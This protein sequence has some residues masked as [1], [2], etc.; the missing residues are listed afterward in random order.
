[1]KE[2]CNEG[3]ELQNLQAKDDGVFD[4]R[5]L[6]TTPVQSRFRLFWKQPTTRWVRRRIKLGF[7]GWGGGTRGKG[8]VSRGRGGGGR[9]RPYVYASHCFKEESTQSRSVSE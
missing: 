4:K 8:R 3:I 7:G 2:D 1:M 9:G 6:T 5:Q